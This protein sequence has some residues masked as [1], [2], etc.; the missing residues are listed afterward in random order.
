MFFV[1]AYAQ[2]TE[3]LRLSHGMGLDLPRATANGDTL[4]V[5]GRASKVYFIKST[6]GGI[7]WSDPI[8]PA[9]SFFGGSTMPDIVFS[10][11]LLHLIWKGELPNGRSQVFHFSS[12]SGEV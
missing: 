10:N 5:V 9:D 11:G 2:W 8:A 4:F 6:D 1:R 7:R 12:G 3:P